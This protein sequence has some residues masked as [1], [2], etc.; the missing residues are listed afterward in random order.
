MNVNLLKDYS[1]Q[2]LLISILMNEDSKT[3]NKRHTISKK[4]E[5]KDVITEK[6]QID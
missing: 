3:V 5:I 2:I 1:V 4:Q 6:T